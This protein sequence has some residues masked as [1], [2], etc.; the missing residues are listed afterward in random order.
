MTRSFRDLLKGII[1]HPFKTFGYIFSYFSMMFTFVKAVTHFFPDIKIEGPS[2]LTAI[3]LLSIG[4]G[5]KKVWKPSSIKIKI[6]QADTTIDVLFG[7][8]FAQN[9]LRVISVNDFFDSKIGAPVSDKS[10]HGIFLQKCFGGLPLP[11]DTQLDA[12][13]DNNTVIEQCSNKEGKQIRYQIGTT[14]I[15]AVNNDRYL[16][17][18]LTNTNPADCKASSDVTHMWYAL[19]CMWQRARTECGGHDVNLPLIGSGLA[20]LGLPTRDLLNVI[21]L[22][23]I[24]E[25]KAKEIC[26]KIRV[27]L[28]ESRFE[29]IDLREVKAFWE[30]K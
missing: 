28:H 27:V 19:H 9:G 12:Q 6:A 2:A 5:L 23:A 22:S 3:A 4:L 25:T 20:G 16:L 30:D 29:D 13:L 7:D 18:A 26:K 1:R 14:A 8:L 17:F 10:L 11:F 15:I 24:T 21:I